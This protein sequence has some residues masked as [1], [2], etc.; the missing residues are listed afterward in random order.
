MPVDLKMTVDL[1][2]EQIQTA[3]KYWLSGSEN[4][5]LQGNVTFNVCAKSE[6]YGLAEHNV[7][8]FT[9]ATAVVKKSPTYSGGGYRD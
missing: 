4:L 1:T 8:T 3:I 9:G 5:A 7:Y 6:G 2:P